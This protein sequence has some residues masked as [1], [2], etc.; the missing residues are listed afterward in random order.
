MQ[1]EK[2]T[3]ATKYKRYLQTSLKKYK[4]AKD[5][6]EENHKTLWNNSKE[7]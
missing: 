3:I 5:L 1:F 4:E 2:L 7:T 6:Y